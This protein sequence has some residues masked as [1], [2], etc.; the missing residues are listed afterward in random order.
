MISEPL[1]QM[2][3]KNLTELLTVRVLLK[4]MPPVTFYFLFKRQYLVKLR[5]WIGKLADIYIFEE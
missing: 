2:S 3:F 4:E 5:A 1:G